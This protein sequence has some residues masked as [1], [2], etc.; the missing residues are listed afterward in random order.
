MTRKLK[1]NN[2]FVI[3]K[4]NSKDTLIKE[5]EVPTDLLECMQSLS[6]NALHPQLFLMKQMKRTLYDFNLIRKDEDKMA[7]IKERREKVSKLQPIFREYNTQHDNGKYNYKERLERLF[8]TLNM[9]TEYPY[10]RN[11]SFLDY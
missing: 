5:W 4:F 8:R 9:S 10:R 1:S 7:W 2:C 3:C 11:M 6:P